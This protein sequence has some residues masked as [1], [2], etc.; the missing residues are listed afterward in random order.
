MPAMKSSVDPTSSRRAAFARGF[1][2]GM[3]APLMLFSSVDLPASAQPMGFQ[4]L[5]R[6]ARPENLDWVRV[7]NQLRAAAA[8]HRNSGSE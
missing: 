5:K 3:A 1:W 8:N 2:K 4:P 6:R 7:G